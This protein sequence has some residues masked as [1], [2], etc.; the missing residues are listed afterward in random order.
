LRDKKYRQRGAG[1]VNFKQIY[2]KK[3]NSIRKKTK[4]NILHKE[5]NQNLLYLLKLTIS[6][7]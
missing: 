2:Q 3:I 6:S 7:E 5:K 4:K 1:P